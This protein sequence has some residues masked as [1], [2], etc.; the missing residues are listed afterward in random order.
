MNLTID[1]F[2]LIYFAG[3]AGHN[4]CS[5]P[6]RPSSLLPENSS[7][8]Q[9][10]PFPPHQAP[11]PCNLFHQPLANLAL[12]LLDNLVLLPLDNLVLLP[13][14]NLVLL[15]LDNLVL[16]PIDNLVL[17]L[18]DNLVLLPFTNLA[19]LAPAKPSLLLTLW[20]SEARREK[21]IEGRQG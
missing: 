4:L 7:E 20:F 18:L 19:L 17:L 21:G 14:D 13:L 11:P 5:L 3:P 9:A 6:P 1:K 8:T 10:C 2:I 15:P 12:L 16:L